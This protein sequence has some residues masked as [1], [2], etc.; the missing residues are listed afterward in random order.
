MEEMF[1]KGIIQRTGKRCKIRRNIDQGF[2]IYHGPIC[3]AKTLMN[4]PC[5]AMVQ[6]FRNG[7]VYCNHHE[8]IEIERHIN[9]NPNNTVLEI[10]NLIENISL[11]VDSSST[12]T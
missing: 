8:A 9:F 7:F 6:K 3:E 12:P 2:C 1:C 4:K 5:K 10:I 11:C